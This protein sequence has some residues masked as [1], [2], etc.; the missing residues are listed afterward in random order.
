MP[1]W[2]MHLLIA[3]KVSEKI[4]IKDYNS[5]LIGNIVPDIN[6]GY[7]IPN[8]SKIITHKDTHY[9]TE[10][11]YKNTN[12]VM[13]YNVKKFVNDNKENINNPIVIGYI[14]HLLTDLYWNDL[15]YEKHGLR[16]EENELIGIKLNNGEKLITDGEG[17]RRTKT[18]DFRIFTNYIYINNLIDIPK[19]QEELY[20]MTK[21]INTIDITNQDIKQSIQYINNVKNSAST[22]KQEYKIFTQ[23]EMLENVEICAEEI[24]KYLKEN[25]I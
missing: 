9:Y 11:K 8:V 3:K 15:T 7:V 4:N 1:A 17:R 23:E 14:T 25:K 10:E 19:Y 20:D 16:N 6:N 24:A 22:L 5:F 2:G 13:Y 21:V 18:D 12:K